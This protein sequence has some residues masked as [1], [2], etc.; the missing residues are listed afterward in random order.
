MM[1]LS[2]LGFDSWFE[3]HADEVF[4]GERS[5][6]RVSAVDRGAYL[7]RNETGELPA[8]LAGTFRFH[9][10]SSVD[11]P[12]VGDW[13]YVQ[14]H[15]EGTL[16]IIHGIFPR[17]T[18]LRRKSAGRNGDVQMIAANIDS[19]LIVQSCHY[20]FNLHRLDRY[21][22]M[23]NEG[24]MEPVLILTKTDRITPEEL[25]K[26]VAA[27][28]QAGI[29]AR[30]LAV[31]NTTGAGLE[32]FRQLLASGQTYCLLG[33]SGVGKTTLINRLIGRAAFE[34]KATSGTGEGTHTTSRRQLIVLESGAL[35]IDT[36][37]MRELGLLG[38]GDALDNSFSDILDLSMEC[39]YADCSH[40]REPGC[41]VLAAIASGELN[42]DRYDSYIKLKKES[43]H[44]EMSHVER[45][46]K[47]RAFGKFVKT[48]TKQMKDHE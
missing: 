11:L 40:T 16:A 12:C 18:F 47:D 5:V 24:R 19:A 32:E 36:P 26:K 6:A 17:K 14:Y 46:R 8:E 10:E 35:L 22:V 34:T 7:V 13:A 21:L 1:T 3:A 29:T 2:D 25:E 38:A 48:A 43:E 39:R 31:S 41:S 42:Q 28:R 23:A 33:S 27:V 30:T 15:N 37:G 4:P 9:A 20:D 45:R 44:Y